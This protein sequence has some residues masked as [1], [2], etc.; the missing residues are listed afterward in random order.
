MSCT[1][2]KGSPGPGQSAGEA[3]KKSCVNSCAGLDGK[4]RADTNNMQT[5]SQET[6]GSKY[7]G[8]R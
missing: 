5:N 7:S 8:E 6:G 4:K 1:K 3:V 2:L